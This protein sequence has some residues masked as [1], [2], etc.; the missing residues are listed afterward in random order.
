MARVA[1][2]EVDV[3][4]SGGLDG[5]ELPAGETALSAVP[6]RGSEGA[7]T[8][9]RGSRVEPGGAAPRRLRNR[10]LALIRRKEV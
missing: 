8:S 6:G 7:E 5:R 2:G 1:A 3:E 10:V 4:V 9:E